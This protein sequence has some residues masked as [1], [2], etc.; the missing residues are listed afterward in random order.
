MKTKCKTKQI[1]N[2]NKT[3]E[4]GSCYFILKKCDVLIRY[5]SPIISR[6]ALEE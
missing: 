6:P 2:N 1:K 5:V 4:K 3:K